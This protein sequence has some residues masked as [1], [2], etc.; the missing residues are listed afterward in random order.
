MEVATAKRNAGIGYRRRVAVQQNVEWSI[1]IG[2]EV[3]VRA[4]DPYERR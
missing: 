4:M 3:V 2:V 1:K